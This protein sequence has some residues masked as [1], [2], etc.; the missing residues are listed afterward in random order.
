MYVAAGFNALR[1]PPII[2]GLRRVFMIP[3]NTV[4]VCLIVLKHNAGFISVPY[5]DA[6]ILRFDRSAIRQ[7]SAADYQVVIQP[8]TSPTGDSHAVVGG[9]NHNIP[10]RMNVSRAGFRVIRMRG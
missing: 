3:A 5:I 1:Q 10:V 9:G 4:V 6:N 8:V 2:S 7:L